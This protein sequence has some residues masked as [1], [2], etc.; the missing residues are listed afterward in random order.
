MRYRQVEADYS[1]LFGEPVLQ[2]QLEGLEQSAADVYTKEV[3]MLFRPMLERAGMCHV[4]GVGQTETCYI[5]A[6]TKYMKEGLTWHVSYS[7]SNLEF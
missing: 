7:P 2:T 1:S 5:Y 4:V 6:V 3:F